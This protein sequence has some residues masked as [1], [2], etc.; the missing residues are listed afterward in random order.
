MEVLFLAI[1]LI[2]I[3]FVA[4][5]VNIFFRKEG[6][7]PETEVGKNRKMKGLGIVCAKCEEHRKYRELKRNQKVRI[8]PAKLSVDFE[9][10]NS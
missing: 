3:S 10:I 8:N 2:G 6:K 5:G 4:L 1:A 7:F 9:G